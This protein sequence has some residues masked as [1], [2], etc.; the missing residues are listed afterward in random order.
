ML[1]CFQKSPQDRRDNWSERKMSQIS[2]LPAAIAADAV[3]N[4]AQAARFLSLSLVH[5]RRLTKRG[6]AP[7]PIRL[8]ERRYGWRVRDLRAWI[9]ER[10]AA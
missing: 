2:E 3:L 7:R 6:A 10:A 8:S 5:F 9:E 4:S 1:H